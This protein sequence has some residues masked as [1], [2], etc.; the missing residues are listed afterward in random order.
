[1]NPRVSLVQYQSPHKLIL[2]FT[3]KEVKEFDFG[4][5]LNYQVKVSSLL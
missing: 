1:M 4:S 2:T 3:N 5:Y